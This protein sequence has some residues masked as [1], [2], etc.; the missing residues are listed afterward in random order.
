MKTLKE[1]LVQIIRTNCSPD[2][3]AHVF[4]K[5][6]NIILPAGITNFDP[7]EKVIKEIV[8]RLCPERH[9]DTLFVMQ[10]TPLDRDFKIYQSGEDHIT[11]T[12]FSS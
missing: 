8:E 12:G 5:Q 6:I 11:V 2:W 1:K 9:E 3:Q 10:S 7:I 4:M